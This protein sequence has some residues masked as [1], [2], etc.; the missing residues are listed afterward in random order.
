MISFVIY[1]MAMSV[2]I[3]MTLSVAAYSKRLEA[4]R[5]PGEKSREK[6]RPDSLI[7]RLCVLPANVLVNFLTPRRMAL[8]TLL[9]TLIALFPTIAALLLATAAAVLF[10]FAIILVVWVPALLLS[11]RIESKPTLPVLALARHV[12]ADLTRH[13]VSYPVALPALVITIALLMGS[14]GLTSP[15]ASSMVLAIALLTTIAGTV[16]ESF[17]VE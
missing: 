14:S 4:Q 13:L 11:A 7:A 15:G 16:I 6:M 10:V 8:L 17:L 1:L 3:T 12:C 2:L 9:L 5:K